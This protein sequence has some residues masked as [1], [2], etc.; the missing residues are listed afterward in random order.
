[1]SLLHR[2][3]LAICNIL[4]LLIWSSG[5]CL[6]TIVVWDCELLYKWV[7]CV[8][9][10]MCR[11][12]GGH[13]LRYHVMNDNIRETLKV[14]TTTEGCRK[15]RL[16]WFGHLCLFMYL[17]NIFKQ[18]RTYRQNHCLQCCRRKEARPRLHRKKD[19]GDGRRKRGR[20]PERWMDFVN[21]EMR[22]IGTTKDEVHD[23]TDWRRIVSAAA[24]PTTKR[25][26]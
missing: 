20:P 17:L 1:M 13:T 5:L 7:V 16:R 14:D 11:W 23:R 26:S 24:T 15:A 25:G 2:I 8:D 3:V 10:G 22:V 6:D 18:G 4:S 12:A 21:R 9:S 19:S